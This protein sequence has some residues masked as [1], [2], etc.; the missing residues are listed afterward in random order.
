MLGER[1]RPTVKFLTCMTVAVLR[2]QGLLSAQLVLDL[3]A[4]AASFVADVEV[5]R[6]IMD[7]VGRSVLPGIELA[8]SVPRVTIVTVGSVCR[9]FCH[10]A[11]AGMKLYLIQSREGLGSW[12]ES[13]CRGVVVDRLMC[14]MGE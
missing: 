6:L 1:G 9:F 11:C 4:M 3:P 12:A 7:S 2:V 5:G 8:L 10:S 14:S 13:A